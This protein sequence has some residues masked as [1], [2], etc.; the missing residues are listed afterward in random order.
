M[1]QMKFKVIKRKGRNNNTVYECQ[2]EICDGLFQT[3][4]I[5]KKNSSMWD[6]WCGEHIKPAIFDTL[7]EAKLF[8]LQSKERFKEEI[9]IVK[10]L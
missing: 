3:M 1:K 2:Q 5:Y 7:K 10:N 9:E 4:Q 8:V 6:V